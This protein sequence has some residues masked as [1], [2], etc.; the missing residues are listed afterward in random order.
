[1]YVVFLQS[2]QLLDTGHCKN[3]A[4]ILFL[5]LLLCP[6]VLYLIEIGKS[7]A[8]TAA[9]LKDSSSVCVCTNTHTELRKKTNQT[10]IL[11]S[12]WFQED[13]CSSLVWWVWECL[14]PFNR[15]DCAI[16]QSVM[17]ALPNVAQVQLKCQ[18]R[19]RSSVCVWRGRLATKRT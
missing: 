16:S 17:S 12:V 15:T 9:D 11:V 19:K 5:S 18:L 13:Q 4:G 14:F 2:R 1:M 6:P 3:Q 8:D 7:A 10:H